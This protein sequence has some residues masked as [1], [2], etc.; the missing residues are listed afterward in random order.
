MLQD[1]GRWRRSATTEQR[2]RSYG[3]SG[4][5]AAGRTKPSCPDKQPIEGFVMYL[6]IPPSPKATG[7]PSITT[8]V[9]VSDS[10]CDESL[11]ERRFVLAFSHHPFLA[12]EHL[13]SLV[14][15]S[16]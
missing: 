16:C 7:D 4:C 5:I 12:G 1:G 10:Q 6:L 13:L 11:M 2:A 14:A 9:L 8:D 15:G 3:H